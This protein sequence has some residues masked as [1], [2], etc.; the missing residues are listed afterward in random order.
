MRQNSCDL[1]FRQ[2]T[3]IFRKP[4]TL[5][6]RW[7]S[8]HGIYIISYFIQERNFLLIC[9][10]EKWILPENGDEVPQHQNQVKTQMATNLNLI[11]RVVKTIRLDMTELQNILESLPATGTVNRHNL[12]V[13]YL[14]R[15]PRGILNSVRTLPSQWPPRL[16]SAHHICSR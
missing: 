9:H 10:G 12:R 15:D 8:F 16:L 4:S 1:C 14:A 5:G 11:L 13:I 2:S 7:G 6:L 3:F